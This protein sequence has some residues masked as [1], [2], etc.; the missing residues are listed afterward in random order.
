MELNQRPRNKLIYLWSLDFWINNPK[1]YN[2]KM[3]VSSTTGAKL[4]GRLHVEE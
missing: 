3:K 2:R 4:T 1:P